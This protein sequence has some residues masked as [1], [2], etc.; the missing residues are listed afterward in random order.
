[1]YL[2]IC[3]GCTKSDRVLAAINKLD[4]VLESRL[5]AND[6]IGEVVQFEVH[7]AENNFIRPRPVKFRWQRGIKI[8]E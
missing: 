4:E 3:I 1:M 6:L 7:H 5:K 8:G 2:L